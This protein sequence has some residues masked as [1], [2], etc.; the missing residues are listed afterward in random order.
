[1]ALILDHGCCDNGV[2]TTLGQV[3]QLVFS[4]THATLIRNQEPVGWGTSLG[5]YLCPVTCE[6]VAGPPS[7]DLG[8]AKGIGAWAMCRGGEG[9]VK[10][11]DSRRIGVGVWSNTAQRTDSGSLGSLAA[12]EV[13]QDKV[14]SKVA[15]DSGIFICGHL[16]WLLYWC[17]GRRQAPA[18]R[19]SRNAE[20]TSFWCRVGVDFGS[21]MDQN[22][23]ESGV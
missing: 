5:Y 20:S 11:G 12:C 9:A 2:V 7:S 10:V 15:A 1:M 22:C 16:F 17:Y 6:W 18:P 14:G 4:T 3:L 8:T 21:G 23:G 13:A 19:G